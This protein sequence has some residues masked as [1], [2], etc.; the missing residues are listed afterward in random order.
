MLEQND[1][2]FVAA[3]VAELPDENTAKSFASALNLIIQG[4][5]ANTDGDEQLFLKG[6]FTTSNG[7]SLV[8]NTRFPKPLF[9]E[10]IGRYLAKEKAQ[11]KPTDG[12]AGTNPSDN[13]VKN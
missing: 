2:E 10:M 1:S 13:P 5:A 3:V 8:L 7:N 12:T 11:P 4:A 9:Q 6:A